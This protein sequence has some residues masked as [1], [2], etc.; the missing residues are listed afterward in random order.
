MSAAPQLSEQAKCEEMAHT[1]NCEN[2]KQKLCDKDWTPVMVET[3]IRNLLLFKHLSEEVVTAILEYADLNGGG[4]I[5]STLYGLAECA[6]SEE[7]RRYAAITGR[8]FE[9]TGNH[10]NLSLEQSKKYVSG[11]TLNERYNASMFEYIMMSW[12]N[13]AQSYPLTLEFN[14]ELGELQEFVLDPPFEPTTVFDLLN[15]PSALERI[16]GLENSLFMPEVRVQTY[17]YFTRPVAYGLGERHGNAVQSK[18]I[19]QKRQLLVALKAMLVKRFLDGTLAFASAQ[20]IDVEVGNKYMKLL[21]LFTNCV[22]GTVATAVRC[23]V[24]LVSKINLDW[25][26]SLSAEVQALVDVSLLISIWYIARRYRQRELPLC[27]AK[28]KKENQ[29]L[30]QI[31]TE[32]GIVHRILVDGKTLEL[33]N[34]PQKTGCYEEEMS[35][36]GSEYFPCKKMPIGAILVSTQSSELALFATFWRLEDYLITARH[37][38]NTL[39]NSTATKYLATVRPTKRGN[40]EVDRSNMFLCPD[41]FFDSTNNVVAFRDVD[42]FAFELEPEIWSRIKVTK[43]NINV[44]SSYNQQ[45][46][47]VGF[48]PAGLLVSAS[49]KTLRSSGLENLHHTASTQKGFSGSP[50]LCGN[51][52]VG[53]H[54]CAEG[55]YNSAVRVELIE[56]LLDVGT[57]MES[58]SKNKK[59]YTYANASYKEHYRQHKWRGGICD[60]QSYK[61]GKFAVLLKNGEATYGWSINDLADAFGIYGN[62][63]K[64]MDYIEDL[65]FSANPLPKS[66]YVDH[67]D[68]DDDDRYRDYENADLESVESVVS[69]ASKASRCLRQRKHKIK[70]SKTKREPILPRDNQEQTESAPGATRESETP[71]KVTRGLKPIHG[72]SAPKQQ[73]AIVQALENHKE[74]LVELGYVEGEFAYPSMSLTEEEGSLRKHLDLFASRIKLVTKEISTEHITRCASVTAEMLSENAYVPDADYDQ[75]SGIMSVI[76]SSTIDPKKASG[77]PY[78][79]NGM[80]LNKIVLEKFGERGFAQEVLNLWNEPFSWRWFTKGEPT[81]RKKLENAMPRGI[82]AMPLHKTVKHVSIF[83]NLSA[84]FVENWRDTPVKYAF[85][86]SLPGHI[87]HLKKCLP[88]RIWQSDKTNWDFMVQPWMVECLSLTFQ[89]LALRNPSW[90]EEKYLAYLEDVDKAVKEVFCQSEYRTSNGTSFK[91]LVDGIMKSG[92]FMTIGGNT[93]LQI[94]CH[95][96]VMLLLEYTDEQIVEQ[97]IVAGGDDVLQDLTGVDVEKYKAV[98]KSIGVDVE[99]EE[100]ADLEHS[101]FFS[102]D[103]R[104]DDLGQWQFF[105]Q[106]FTKHVE[107]LKVNKIEDVGGALLSHMG[108]YRHHPERFLFFENLYHELRKEHPDYFPLKPL[109]SRQTLLAIQYGHE[110]CGGW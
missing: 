69:R 2:I 35:M 50:L 29:Y 70:R 51:S 23:C 40:F 91:M 79:E 44:K 52:V 103:I 6:Y 25:Y 13:H 38:S 78:A 55:E 49:G 7:E 34:V 9:K 89:K 86:P 101:E 84:S 17:S 62:L 54:V 80:P 66:H 47:S 100:V 1:Q 90:T 24:K 48:T 14:D 42:C 21:V 105:M 41:E 58:S 10:V 22:L 87:K 68:Y 104:R 36:P 95:V 97:P 108:N 93:T 16:I 64:N 33:H 28:E 72:P 110:S 81:K 109:K 26:R 19:L 8:M 63:E 73:P 30:G 20:P 31:A 74:R 53:M 102:Q 39:A 75:L 56:Y 57:G 65:F 45:V 67:D 106:R 61:D 76:N 15:T 11:V 107:H 94:I 92:W 83:K 82:N 18:T 77:F 43:C 99:L 5:P 4:Y 37:V 32:T 71:Y 12:F 3:G 98:S 85:C 27:E 88:G 46:H 59:K 60:I 96:M